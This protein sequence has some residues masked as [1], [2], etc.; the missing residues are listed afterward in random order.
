[1]RPNTVNPW[2]RRKIHLQHHQVSGTKQDLEER[3][4]G[5]GIKHPLTRLLVII[6]GLAGLLLFRKVFTQEI[7]GFSFSRVFNA[8]FPFATAYFVVLY[9]MI[10]YYSLH[11]IFPVNEHLSPF[12]LSVI[13]LFNFLMVILVLPNILRSSS[14]NVV[15]SSMHYYGGVEDLHQQ[16]HVINSKW[17]Q[18]CTI[19]LSAIVC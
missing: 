12:F 13:N 11:L 14:L 5:N 4:V 9:S 16:T 1:M 6:D 3:L 8:G 2:F 15:T 10:V 19:E 17:F 7:K 18:P